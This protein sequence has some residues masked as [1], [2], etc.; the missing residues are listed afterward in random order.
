M[1]IVLAWKRK[2]IARGTK[3]SIEVTK[4]EMAVNLLSMHQSHI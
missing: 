3:N 2:G 4:L 1:V